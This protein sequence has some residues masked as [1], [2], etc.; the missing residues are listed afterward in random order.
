M[1][2]TRL[3]PYTLI[4][5]KPSHSV[6]RTEWII[7]RMPP[8]QTYFKIPLDTLYY[9]IY[10]IMRKEVS[11]MESQFSSGILPENR[12]K[13]RDSQ[14]MYD[15]KNARFYILMTYIGVYMLLACKNVYQKILH[16]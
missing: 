7:P 5:A 10:S 12:K 13:A 8:R 16:K 3:I 15:K 6:W 2:A 1:A 11:G 9:A 14:K 4:R